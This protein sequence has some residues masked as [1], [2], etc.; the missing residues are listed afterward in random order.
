MGLILVMNESY[1]VGGLNARGSLE[2]RWS[3]VKEFEWDCGVLQLC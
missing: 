3:T 2:V 1:E